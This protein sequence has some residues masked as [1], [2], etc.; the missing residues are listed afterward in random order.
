VLDGL[1]QELGLDGSSLNS[2][3]KGPAESIGSASDAPTDGDA[4]KTAAKP[5]A[6]PAPISGLKSGE[7]ADLTAK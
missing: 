6:K 2:L 4:S 3:V 7:P 1:M 5:K